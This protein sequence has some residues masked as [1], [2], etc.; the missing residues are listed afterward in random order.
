MATY[1]FIGNEQLNTKSP[2]HS[3]EQRQQR[4][5]NVA[6]A[7]F[8]GGIN[9]SFP[10]PVTQSFDLFMLVKISSLEPCLALLSYLLASE[11]IWFGDRKQALPVFSDCF[12]SGEQ[13]SNYLYVHFSFGAVMA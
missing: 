9:I 4:H 10:N 1:S 6:S 13:L 8:T 5:Q 3:R 2:H 11:S 7:A 12:P